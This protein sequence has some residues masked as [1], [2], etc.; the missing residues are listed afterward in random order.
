MELRPPAKIAIGVVGALGTIAALHFTIFASRADAYA[1][2]RNQYETAIAAYNAAGST[3]SVSDINRFKYASLSREIEYWENVKRLGIFLPD[4]YP[5]VD[6]ETALRQH[7]QSYWDGVDRLLTLRREGE[8]GQNPKLTFLGPNGW[9]FVETL[10][11]ELTSRGIA[12][13]DEITNLRN[14][15]RLLNSLDPSSAQFQQRTNN[16][17]LLLRRVGLDRGY[18]DNLKQFLGEQVAALYT[19]NRIGIVLRNLPADFFGAGAS[20]DLKRERMYTLFRQEWATDHNNAEAWLLAQRQTEALVNMIEVAREK[21]ITEITYVKL[22]KITELRWEEFKP[23]EAT[24]TPD[25]SAMWGMDE[26]GGFGMDEFGMDG[27]F[28]GRFGG[29]FDGVGAGGFGGAAAAPAQQ[30]GEAVGLICPV[31]IWVQGPNSAVMDFLYTL[32]HGHRPYELDRVRIRSVRPADGIVEA[33]AFFNV[34]GYANLVGADTLE[35]VQCRLVRLIREKADI[36]LRV[37][38]VELALQEGFVVSRDGR[39]ELASPSPT[40]CPGDERTP[41][42]VAMDGEFGM[43]ERF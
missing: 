18:R 32:T 23:N 3:P 4:F 36:A 43:D 1:Q 37:G 27:E 12:V 38:A 7:R 29:R 6:L 24:P 26:F 42:P 8:A 2:A 16:Y 5:P 40:P 9:N 10:P 14:E 31:E 13:E 25:T 15:D 39:N 30:P 28:G 21:G 22:H 17:N 34:I 19:I 33:R 20:E 35:S 11:Q 41:E